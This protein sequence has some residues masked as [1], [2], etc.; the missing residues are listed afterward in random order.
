MRAMQSVGAEAGRIARDE[1]PA[2]AAGRSLRR[3]I[4]AISERRDGA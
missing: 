3:A 1:D 4:K 2:R